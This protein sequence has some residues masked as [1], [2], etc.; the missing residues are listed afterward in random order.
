[1]VLAPDGQITKD[2]MPRVENKDEV[3]AYI[4]E[5][6]QKNDIDRTDTS[7]GKTGCELKGV[8]AIN[9]VNGKEVPLYIGDFVLAN[10]GTGGTES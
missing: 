2:L 9:P 7:K 8:F 1:M 5:T 10:Y 3:Q 4:N 6:A